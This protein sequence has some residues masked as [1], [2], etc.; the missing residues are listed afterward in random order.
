MKRFCRSLALAGSVLGCG[1]APPPPP[2]APPK[3]CPPIAPTLAITATT[4]ANAVASGEGRP[5]QVRIYQLKSD[6]RL[7]AAS[8]EDVWQNDA[9]VLEGELVSV[10]EQTIFPG[11]TLQVSVTP[12]PDAHYLALVGLFREPKGKDWL[13]S[14]ELAAPPSAPPCPTK[15]TSIPVWIDRMQ[16]QDGTGREADSAPNPAEPA[17]TP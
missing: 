7:R 12:K 1:S 10:E 5:L 17:G 11:K 16:I 13:L 3:P 6:A 15:P 14:Y 4:E 2:A 9:K 8:F